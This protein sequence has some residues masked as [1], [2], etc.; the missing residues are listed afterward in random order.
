MEIEFFVFTVEAFQ[1]FKFHDSEAKHHKRN[2]KRG[3]TVTLEVK[4]S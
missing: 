3:L 1:F 4:Q 2:F